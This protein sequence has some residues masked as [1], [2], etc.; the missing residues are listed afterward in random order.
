MSKSST[1]H[2]LYACSDKYAPIAG[3]SMKSLF[4]TN[5]DIDICLHILMDDVSVENQNRIMDMVNR[6]KQRVEF[7]DVKPYSSIIDKLG[8]TAFQSSIVLFI[9]LFAGRYVSKDIKRIIYVDSDTFFEGSI[10]QWNNF[11]LAGKPV[12]MASDCI[13]R[14]YMKVIGLKED[15]EYFNGGLI[16]FDMAR[17]RKGKFEEMIIDHCKNIRANYPLVIQDIM[18]VV[19]HDSIHRIGIEN[20]FLPQWFLYGFENYKQIYGISEKLMSRQELEFGKNHII[21]HH[22]SGNTLGRPWYKGSIH[23]KAKDYLQCIRDSEW[24][25]AEWEFPEIPLEYKVQLLAHQYLSSRINV[26]LG[27][28]LQNVFYRRVYGI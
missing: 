23:P 15:S 9:V 27:R 20:N 22:F 3:I 10:R 5:H 21:M 1:Y 18:N 25:D 12:A 6:Y 17:W 24:Y 19:L 4:E 11:D 8:I 2:L 26:F 28:L 14:K 13:N 7:I 16:I